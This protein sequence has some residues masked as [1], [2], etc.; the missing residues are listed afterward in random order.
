M[1]LNLFEKEAQ[2]FKNLPQCCPCCGGNLKAEGWNT[3]QMPGSSDKAD[4][5]GLML[6]CVKDADHVLIVTNK[7]NR[8]HWGY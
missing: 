6:V 4:W 3:F 2:T 5:D 7:A 8:K 1:I